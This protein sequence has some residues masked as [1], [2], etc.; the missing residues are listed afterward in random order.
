MR[1][2]LKPVV[3]QAIGSGSRLSARGLAVGLS[4]ILAACS[5]PGVKVTPETANVQGQEAEARDVHKVM[6]LTVA[7]VG[8]IMLGTDYPHD[9]LPPPDLNLLDPVSHTL[10]Q[11][12]ITFGNLEGVMMDGGKPFKQC[13]NPAHCYLFR[14]PSRYVEQLKQAGFDV[15]SLANNHARDFGE[16]GRSSS[17]AVL[18]ASGILHSGRDGD[19]ASWE[20]K[21]KKIALI[22]F[23][24]FAGANSM[25]ALKQVREQ[26]TALDHDHD[27]V[28][29]SIHAGAEGA[30]VER[31]PFAR[32]YYHG[33]NRGDVV[34]FARLAVDSGADLVLGHGPHV[35]RA[36]E[37]YNGR[38][39]AYS[40][41]NFATYWGIKVTGANGLAP[42]LTAELAPDGRFLGGKI[43]SARQIRPAGPIPDDDHTAARMMRELTLSDFPETPLIIDE[44]GDIS[45]VT[46]SLLSGAPPKTHP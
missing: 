28:L 6:S 26:I 21:G 8:D 15:L 24:P 37:L 41:G 18:E 10:Q 3:L 16:E 7:A 42:I 44:R 12:D 5:T 40:L 35:P 9:R 4:F 20:V 43:V 14:T 25:H 34:E 19:I 2:D 31:V 11:A 30:G 27:I 46:P 39:I 36:V 13:S 17:M 29:V 22:A 38:L 33:E 32:E 1:N 23:A 45:V